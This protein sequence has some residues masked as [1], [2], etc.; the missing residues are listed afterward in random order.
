MHKF[1][2]AVARVKTAVE[3]IIGLLVK[4]ECATQMGLEGRT[5][6]VEFM[7]QFRA[8]FTSTRRIEVQLAR[9][10][11]GSARQVP[12]RYPSRS[13][14]VW[15]DSATGREWHIMYTRQEVSGA[16]RGLFPTRL[17]PTR[18]LHG[19]EFRVP[20]DENLRLPTLFGISFSACTTNCVF[21][22]RVFVRNSIFP[23]PGN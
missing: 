20:L 11:F 6:R 19:I 17:P 1:D 23:S 4:N 7:I 9:E 8:F 5:S 13:E 22:V 3:N 12:A 21:A 2:T 14:E 15:Q 10:I 18:D 16:H